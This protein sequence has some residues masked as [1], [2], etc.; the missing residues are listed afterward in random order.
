MHSAAPALGC[1]CL[2]A[3][4]NVDDRRIV[5]IDLKACGAQ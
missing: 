3:R 2:D 4:Q 5:M 1:L